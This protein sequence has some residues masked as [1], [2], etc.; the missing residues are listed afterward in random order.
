MGILSILSRTF[1][2]VHVRASENCCPKR[3]CCPLISML[4]FVFDDLKQVVESSPALEVANVQLLGDEERIR[5][6]NRLWSA[7]IKSPAMRRFVRVRNHG[8]VH[9]KQALK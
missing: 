8:E 5:N 7:K 9:P 1:E 6:G 4:R 2:R 3:V